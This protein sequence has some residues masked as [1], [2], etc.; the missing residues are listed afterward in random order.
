MLKKVQVLFLTILV[1]LCM[2][3]CGKYNCEKDGHV[4]VDNGCAS[5][6]T[7]EECGTEGD[8]VDHTVD[9]KGICT[10]CG[11]NAGIELNYNNLGKYIDWDVTGRQTKNNNGDLGITYQ[12]F[13]KSRSSSYTFKNAEFTIIA[14]ITESGGYY[15]SGLYL[16]TAELDEK[17]NFTSAEHTQYVKGITNIRIT[18]DGIYGRVFIN[19]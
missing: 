10:K 5:Y 19:E 17:G 3:A 4:W 16:M 2:T 15:T 7:C 12:V 6:K 9:A 14:D 18:S 8:Y 13:V 11:E 1:T